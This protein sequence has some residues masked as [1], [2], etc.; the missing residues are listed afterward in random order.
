MSAARK[1]PCSVVMITKNEEQSLPK[2]L[3]SVK[4]FEEIIVVD[5]ESA[6]R[7][8]A[9]AQEF[10][11]KV[12]TRRFDNFAAQKNFALKQASCEWIFSLDADELPDAELILEI[13]EMIK[14]PSADTAGYRIRR[15]NRHFGRE[16][17]WGGQ[18]TDFPI[19]VFQKDKGIF[20]GM[21]H[22]KAR[23]QGKIGMLKGKLSHESNRTVNEYLEKL[24]RYTTLEA[25]ATQQKRNQSSF[26][27]WGIKP[28]LRFL[29]TYFF[30]LG[31]LDGFEGFLFHSLSSFYLTAKEVRLV[32][33][34]GRKS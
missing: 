15:T 14:N 22:E 31:F 5:S 20:S 27:Y 28:C 12:C 7:T 6:D 21:V 8:E 32:E 3:D 29:Y 13:A 9:V 18:R 34:A 2:V 23:V 25:K 4:G 19:R 11:A 24:S 30:R 33:E 26:W 17:I 16:L 1:I 10:G